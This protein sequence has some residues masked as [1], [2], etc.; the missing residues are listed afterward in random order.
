MKKKGHRPVSLLEERVDVH[1]VST[2]HR[3]RL[4]IMRMQVSREEFVVLQGVKKIHG[5]ES[6]VLLGGLLQLLALGPQL[7][8]ESSLE[9]E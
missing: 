6:S 3:N 9:E 5:L 2:L 8:D 1:R 7:S 4:L